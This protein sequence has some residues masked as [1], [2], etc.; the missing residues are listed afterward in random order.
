MIAPTITIKYISH[1]TYNFIVGNPRTPYSDVSDEYFV[2]STFAT[3]MGEFL[4]VR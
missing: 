2:A 1:S 3:C 4:S